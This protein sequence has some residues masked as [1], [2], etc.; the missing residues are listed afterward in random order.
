[1]RE[2]LL[3]ML[4]I[5]SSVLHLGCNDL[6]VSTDKLL[7]SV[8]CLSAESFGAVP[9]DGQDD[10]QALQSAIDYAQQSVSKCLY[11]TSGTYNVTR[12]PLAGTN[13][14]ASLRITSMLTLTGNPGAKLS[15][16]GSGV[17][18]GSSTPRD[19]TLL[20]VSSNAESV[21][22]SH[23]EFDGSQRTS[24]SE[25]THLIQLLG[26]VSDVTLSDL[27]MSLPSI[28][29]NSGGDCI[30]LL[31]QP[32][33]QVRDFTI[34]RIEALV[35][36][37]SW[38]GFQRE[39][40]GGVIS[41]SKTYIVGD[42]AIDMEPTGANNCDGQGNCV[43]TI[44]NIL[45]EGLDLERGSGSTGVTISISG[46]GPNTAD[47]IVLR[48]SQIKDGTVFLVNTSNVTL[49]NLLIKNYQKT[50]VPLHSI[51]R[52]IALKIVN[53]VIER[54]DSSISPGPALQISGQG[55]AKPTDVTV[56]DSSVIQHGTGLTVSLEDLEK[57][58]AIRSK[59]IYD[60]PSTSNK[61]VHNRSISSHIQGVTIVDSQYSSSLMGPGLSFGPYVDSPDT[62]VRVDPI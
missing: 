26:P 45:M 55:D 13:N 57:F 36:D 17:I 60:G 15:M 40:D 4:L 2:L 9:N 18:P 51:K 38:I 54:D 37:R 53:C 1:M 62:I 47:N 52:T 23:L 12:R 32:S 56:I 42:Q 29:P 43:P 46:N 59:F 30:R 11:L 50:Q 49:Q 34:T 14:I 22:I 24:T 25:Q 8:D 39:V 27:K 21:V 61:A 58:I 7:S 20:S 19:W 35:C 5:I 28:G 3:L 16:M 44:S 31:G 6:A 48:D 41:D 33:G 10:R